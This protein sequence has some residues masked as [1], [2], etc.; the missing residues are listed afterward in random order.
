MTLLKASESM[1]VDPRIL[2]ALESERFSELGAAVFVRGHLRRYADLVRESP[3]ELQRLYEA[4]GQAPGAPDLTRVPK[5]EPTGGDSMSLLLPGITLVIAIAV[6]GSIWWFVKNVSFGSAT[7]AS[8]TSS[9]PAIAPAAASA[10][11][12][13]PA[14]ATS[15]AAP[16]A[17]TAQPAA[18][19]A[20]AAAAQPGAAK[21]SVTAA[22][23]AKPTQLT[24]HFNEDSWTEVYDA[25]N[26]RLMY[27]IGQAGSVH[28]LS[29][30]APL[31]VLLGN[32]GGVTLE[33]NGQ[34]VAIPGDAHGSGSVEFRITRAGHALPR[35]AAAAHAE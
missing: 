5:S 35:I 19:V 28:S 25:A 12:A 32:A 30:S 9:A 1:H 3:A 8:V 16:S 33:V 14:P 27:D 6:I 13:A 29:G 7:T 4:S 17:A 21:A 20:S 34:T 26:L 2:E 11:V 24:L 15:A 18:S 10:A 23:S 22:V 31:R